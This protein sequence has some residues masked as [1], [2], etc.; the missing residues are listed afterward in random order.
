MRYANPE[1][2]REQLYTYE[3]YDQQTEARYIQ[4]R[5]VPLHLRYNLSHWVSAGAGA[6]VETRINTRY[7]EDRTYY[8]LSAAAEIEATQPGSDDRLP[9]SRLGVQPFIDLN[10]GRT[11]L[12]PVLG[13]RYLY[14]HQQGHVGHGYLAWRF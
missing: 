12:G 2:G 9:V 4:L 5:A 6:M 1:T 13:L 7:A 10:F 11:Y 8:L 14:G 3:R